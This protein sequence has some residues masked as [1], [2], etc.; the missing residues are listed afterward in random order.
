VSY[1]EFEY[2]GLGELY[3]EGKIS[4]AGFV[5]AHADLSDRAEDENEA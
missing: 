2:L 4:Y 1:R 3:Q 5:V